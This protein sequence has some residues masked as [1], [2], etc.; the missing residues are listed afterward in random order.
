M[1]L[2]VFFG[3]IFGGEVKIAAAKAYPWMQIPRQDLQVITSAWVEQDIRLEMVRQAKKTIDIVI[4]DQRIDFEVAY[5][6]LK[7]LRD[8]A[9]RGVKV[10]FMASWF[11]QVATDFMRLAP[12]YLVDSP[13]RVPIEFVTFGGPSMKKEWAFEDGVHEKLFIVD[14]KWT[15]TTGRG[16]A[17]NYMNWIDTAFLLRGA[18]VAQTL[19]VYNEVWKLV[20]QEADLYKAP[21]NGYSEERLEIDR[22]IAKQSPGKRTPAEAARLLELKDWL[23][24]T[25]SPGVLTSVGS[26]SSAT[27]TRG[28]PVKP[29]AKASP[30]PTL[31]IRMIHH[32]FLAQMLKLSMPPAEYDYQERL[33]LIKDPVVAAV[34]EKIP[35]TSQLA[36]NS[37]S[38][39][40]HPEIKQLLLKSI[41]KGMW[42]S[43]FTNSKETFKTVAL[44]PFPWPVVL[45]DLDDLLLH[46]ADVYIYKVD[47]KTPPGQYLHRKVL[48][49]DNTVFF[50]SHNYN[51][52]STVANDEVSFEVED[53]EFAARMRGLFEESVASHGQLLDP[54]A[55]HRERNSTEVLRWLFTPLLGFF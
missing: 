54:A 38:V 2:L 30:S 55:V 42:A 3:L 33:K 53:A 29:N 15:L 23:A 20:R 35:K 26:P 6:L 25:P 13:P 17:I 21:P 52:P 1:G 16:H 11:P 5:P 8:A 12:R 32:D 39:I 9:D 44:V 19:T 46:G 43:V 14:G 4:F 40:L 28:G 48:I 31:R 37:L 45:P 49:M 50:G 10:R 36:M 18:L 34:K 7:V 22:K 24:Q 47:A 27:P 41:L 51:I